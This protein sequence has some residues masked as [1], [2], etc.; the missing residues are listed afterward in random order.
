MNPA[1]DTSPALPELTS[2]EQELLNGR[3]WTT[4]A[5]LLCGATQLPVTP[6]VTVYPPGPPAALAKCRT[7]MVAGLITQRATAAALQR[8]YTPTLPPIPEGHPMPPAAALPTVPHQASHQTARPTTRQATR[9]SPSGRPPGLRHTGSASSA[10]SGS[11]ATAPPSPCCGH[12]SP[13]HNTTVPRSP[14]TPSTP[15]SKRHDARLLP[16][17][18]GRPPPGPPTGGERPADEEGPG[19]APPRRAHRQACPDHHPERAAGPLPSQ[20]QPPHEKNSPATGCNVPVPA[21][22]PTAGAGTSALCRRGPHAWR[23]GHLH[24]GCG[25]ASCRTGAPPAA[26]GAGC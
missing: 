25:R 16:L 2:T 1:P 6:I 14:S 22:G 10:W 4:G 3:P 15:G 20:R 9:P 18:A 7:C 19:R 23:D 8:P 17:T 13:P 24:V 12:K 5:C 21:R 26:G 11:S